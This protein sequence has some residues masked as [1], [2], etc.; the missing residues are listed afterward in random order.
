MTDLL[1]AEL[2]P[3]TQD[4]QSPDYPP[5]V[6]AETTEIST[7]SVVEMLL[8][9]HGRLNNFLRNEAYERELVPRLLAV[10]LAG[11]AV[12][13]V[14]VTA[15]INALWVKNGF[16]LPYLPPAYWNDLSVANLTLGYTLGLIAANGICLPSFYF[17]GLLA[18]IKTTMLGVTAHAIKGMAAGAVALV[19]LLPIYVALSLTSIVFPLGKGWDLTCVVWGLALPFAAGIFGAVNLYEGFVGLA[20]TMTCSNRSTRQCFLRRLILAWVGCSTFVI[21]VVV[22]SLWDFLSDLTQQFGSLV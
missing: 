11:F 13:G 15:I 16:W 8:K 4:A 14:A 17:Y 22:Y 1:I 6:C 19:G 21:P 20:D 7:A 5:C 3:K 10:A 18:G 12:Y 2:A 9:D